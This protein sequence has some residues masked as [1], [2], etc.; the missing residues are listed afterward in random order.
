MDKAPQICSPSP[1]GTSYRPSKLPIFA[2]ISHFLK[3]LP[4]CAFRYLKACVQAVPPSLSSSLSFLSLSISFSLSLFISLPPS[5]PPF[6]V[7]FLSEESQAGPGAHYVAQSGLKCQEILLPQLHKYRDSSVCLIFFSGIL[8]LTMLSI[9]EREYAPGRSQR[10]KGWQ[11]PLSDE[12]VTLTLSGPNKKEHSRRK[13]L[14]S[15]VVRPTM[16][17]TAGSVLGAHHS[18]HS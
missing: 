4:A 15:Y 3:I 13:E 7:C 9:L 5:P 16:A 18:P 12:S 11:R 6:C 17:P 1:Q 14:R 10:R 8:S 2:I